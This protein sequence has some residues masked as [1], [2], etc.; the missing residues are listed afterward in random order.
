MISDL[1][2]AKSK[3]EIIS[4]ANFY[5]SNQEKISDLFHYFE[6]NTNKNLHAHIFW[7]LRSCFEKKPTILTPFYTKI[8][9]ILNQNGLHPGVYRNLLAILS[10]T[11]YVFDESETELICNASFDFLISPKSPIAIKVHAMS[12]LEKIISQFPELKTELIIILEDQLPF[13]SAGFKSRAQKLLIRLK[14]N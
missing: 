11:T 2:E 1:I 7:V 10:E 3:A 6:S 5:L 13:S 9:H 8:V 14:T 12:V 4:Q